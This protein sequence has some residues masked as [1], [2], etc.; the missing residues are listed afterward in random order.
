MSAVEVANFSGDLRIEE[1]RIEL[2]DPL[3]AAFPCGH[4]GPEG[5]NVRTERA[6][7]AE[8][9]DDNSSISPVTRHGDLLIG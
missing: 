5:I 9:R 4:A 7:D 2:S 1:R 8:A 3:D 6:H